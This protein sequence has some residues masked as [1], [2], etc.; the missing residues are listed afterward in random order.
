MAMFSSLG[1]SYF[2]RPG[3]QLGASPS[4]FSSVRFR[5]VAKRPGK[6]HMRSCYPVSLEL[7]STLPF[8]QDSKLVSLTVTRSHPL[9]VERFA[10]ATFV[11]PFISSPRR[12]M[13]WWLWLYVYR[14]CLKLLNTSDLSRRKRLFSWLFFLANHFAWTFPLTPAHQ[15]LRLHRNLW[16]WKLNRVFVYR[17]CFCSLQ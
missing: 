10:A 14:Q 17:W 9:K 16:R 1:W 15:V 12:S 8:M 7:S 4:V 13:V 2:C 11:L 3:S 5:V 6:P